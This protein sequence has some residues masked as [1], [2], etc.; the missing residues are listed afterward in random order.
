MRSLGDSEL[1]T[2]D[3]GILPRRGSGGV[4]EEKQEG[5]GVACSVEVSRNFK[6]GFLLPLKNSSEAI[7]LLCLKSKSRMKESVSA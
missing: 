3:T 1:L 4:K 5:M 6:D 7:S 2:R